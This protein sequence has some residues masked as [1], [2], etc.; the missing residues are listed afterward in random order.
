[1]VCTSGTC[2]PGCREVGYSCVESGDCCNSEFCV[3]GNGS[4]TRGHCGCAVGGDS[5]NSDE[6]C[7]SGQG[8]CQDGTCF[9]GDVAE[10]TTTTTPVCLPDGVFCAEH[11]GCCSMACAQI[12]AAGAFWCTC[13]GNGGECINAMPENCCSGRCE[14]GQCMPCLPDQQQCDR[15]SDCCN[16]ICIEVQGPDNPDWCGCVP[17]GQPC[18]DSGQCCS[19]RCE[20]V[21]LTGDP[22]PAFAE[23]LDCVPA[24]CDTLGCGQHADDG[25]GSPLDCG[26]CQEA[27]CVPLSCADLGVACGSTID[28]CGNPIDCGACI[29]EPPVPACIEDN[30]V[31]SLNAECCSGCCPDQIGR[32]VRASVC[33]ALGDSV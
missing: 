22:V 30:D 20:G 13:I 27:A 12:G 3:G 9:G 10:E 25:C 6:D 7:C 23:V 5:C 2:Q 1:L 4:G 18:D 11:E 29:E 31:C 28:N 8:P 24:G 16:D 26:P 19:E 32:C 17:L 15:N 33:E 21:C 14:S